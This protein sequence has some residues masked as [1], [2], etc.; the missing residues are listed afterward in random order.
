MHVEV[1]GSNVLQALVSTWQFTASDMPQY[2]PLPTVQLR[3]SG[4]GK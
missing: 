1:T 2:L 4:C 3:K